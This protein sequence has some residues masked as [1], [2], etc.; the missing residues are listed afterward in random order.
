M[1]LALELQPRVLM[2]SR[3]IQH[4][5]YGRPLPAATRDLT[6]HVLPEPRNNGV[7]RQSNAQPAERPKDGQEPN[8]VSRDRVRAREP[9]T[10]FPDCSSARPNRDLLADYGID[11]DLDDDY[12]STDYGHRRYGLQ[13]F[14]DEPGE[15]PRCFDS[16]RAVAREQR[17][18]LK[19]H[20]ER[21][22]T[23][24][25]APFAPGPKAVA[26]GDESIRE[27]VCR[28]LSRAW[29]IDVSD[30]QVAVIAGEVTLSGSIDERSQKHRAED[31]AAGVAGVIDVHNQL[32]LRRAR[33][34]VA[35]SDGSS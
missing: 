12:S 2:A 32:R 21:P 23:T 16:A 5:E 30:I 9:L 35:A 4:R 8:E 17:L 33:R 26:R 34:S 29:A 31:L 11:D 14:D 15:D 25:P 27:E 3:R 1:K 24:G 19:R 22:P 18:Y 28:C 10:F 6:L 7:A 20:F 13:A